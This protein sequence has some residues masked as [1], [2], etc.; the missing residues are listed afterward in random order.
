MSKDFKIFSIAVSI[1]VALGIATTVFISV[2]KSDWSLSVID[3]N[4]LLANGDSSYAKPEIVLDTYNGSQRT[5][6][7]CRVS[8]PC[9]QDIYKYL[10]KTW[11]RSGGVE[12]DESAESSAYGGGV[13]SSY[14]HTP[15]SKRVYDYFADY[16]RI[17]SPVG[18]CK[19]IDKKFYNGQSFGLFYDG[20]MPWQNGAYNKTYIGGNL[21]TT[22]QY[23]VTTGV[24]LYVNG[25]PLKQYKISLSA[26][27]Y[28]IH[29]GQGYTRVEYEWVES[30][31]SNPS[32]PHSSYPK[33]ANGNI[34][35]T[36]QGASVLDVTP[37]P[38]ISSA[39]SNLYGFY[40]I[41]AGVEEK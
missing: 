19:V 33:D 41:I 20:Q 10:L 9:S 16:W 2:G 38:V 15:W 1:L 27:S 40:L 24:K 7:S 11:N 5:N 35:I 37:H 14:Q 3:K 4:N 39:K 26:A 31:I 12:Q 13:Y 17:C 6:Y 36:A 28:Y 34:I 23:S 21:I 25:N 30:G 29:M 32:T 8:S 18:G 22:E